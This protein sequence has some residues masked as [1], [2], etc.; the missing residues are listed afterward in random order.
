MKNEKI[1]VE[2][3]VL[4]ISKKFI[5]DWGHSPSMGFIAGQIRPVVSLEAVRQT[6]IKLEMKNKV[7]RIKMGE[8]EGYYTQFEILEEK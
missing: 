7:R 1:S 8:S 2:D 6:L 3:Q 4:E 5:K